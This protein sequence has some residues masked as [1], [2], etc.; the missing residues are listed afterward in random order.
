MHFTDDTN[1]N[2]HKSSPGAV[3]VGTISTSALVGNIDSQP[4]LVNRE[5]SKSFTQK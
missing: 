3:N 4:S 5:T 2:E 1:V